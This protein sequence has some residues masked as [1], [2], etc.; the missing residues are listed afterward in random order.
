[1]FKG[2]PVE[3]GRF[4]PGDLPGTLAFGSGTKLLG[5]IILGS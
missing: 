3:A 2:R 4:F 1:M 5:R